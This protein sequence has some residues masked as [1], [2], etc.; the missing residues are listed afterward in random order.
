[1]NLPTSYNWNNKG[2]YYGE[3]YKNS[4][5]EIYNIEKKDPMSEIVVTPL[6]IHLIDTNK[7]I[8]LSIYSGIL[9]I[10]Q[11]PITLCVKPELGFL[12]TKK[13]KEK[14]NPDPYEIKKNKCLSLNKHC[15]IF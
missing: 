2:E 12:I 15:L 9:G 11:D 8:D 13:V 1:M 3:N 5:F 10:S 6:K 4:K 7:D 14:I